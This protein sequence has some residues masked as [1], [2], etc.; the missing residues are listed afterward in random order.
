MNP[1]IIAVDFD[2]TIANNTWPDLGVPFEGVVECLSELVKQGHY[3]IIWTC[4]HDSVD[5]VR[6]WLHSYRIP[7][8]RINEHHP[9]LIELYKNDTRK[10]SA[11]IYIDDK[12]LGGLPPWGMMLELINKHA[13][14]ITKTMLPCQ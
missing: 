14:T 8:H 13:Q 4:R 2:G 11:D 6:D 3:I 5:E 9:K 10:I 1:L 7:F 12:N